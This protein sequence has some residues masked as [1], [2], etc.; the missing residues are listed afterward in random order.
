MY[1]CNTAVASKNVML[2]RSAAAG[3]FDLENND[4][5]K[6]DDDKPANETFR[7]HASTV[8]EGDLK[9]VTASGLSGVR[10]ISVT[11]ESGAKAARIFDL[12]LYFTEPDT[13]VKQQGR[14]FDVAVQG[15][16]VLSDLDIYGATGGAMRELVREIPGI[17]V[18]NT[19]ELL[20]TPS[21]GE[22]V[23][24]GLELIHVPQKQLPE[25]HPI[26]SGGPS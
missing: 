18:S 17:A 5:G 25:Q 16:E 9:W 8:A 2:F 14:V 22:P 13:G 10:K 4:A 26:A 7:S 3:F 1:G 12:K 6:K 24:S 21:S 23:I 15:K 20:F 19:L 11:L